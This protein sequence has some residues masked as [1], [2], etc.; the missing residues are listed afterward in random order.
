MTYILENFYF[1]SFEA[2]T[3]VEYAE[4]AFYCS[5]AFLHVI[6]YVILLQN[7]ENLFAL[8]KDSD[9]IIQKRKFLFNWNL[10]KIFFKF[11]NK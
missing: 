1:I 4:S 5:V 6:S 3:F 8:L 7:R 10:F 11:N 9:D 2:E